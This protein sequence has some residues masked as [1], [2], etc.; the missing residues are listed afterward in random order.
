MTGDDAGQQAITYYE[1]HWDTGG[2]SWV[3]LV[4]QS[5]GS[6]TFSHTQSAG[7]TAGGA[8]QFKYRAANQHGVGEYSAVATI[9]ASA[10]PDQLASATTAN[11]GASVIVTWPLT[12]S[13]RGAT[14]TA[15]RVK[16][17]GTDGVYRE[18]AGCSPTDGGG[19]DDQAAFT[20]R[21]C[22]L[23]MTLFT[24]SPLSLAIDAPII[25]AVEAYNNKGHS[26]PSADDATGATAQT[27]P[28]EGPV[29]ARGGATTTTSLEV[30]WNEVTA[31][32]GNGGAAVTAYRVYWDQGLA[33]SSATP[34]LNNLGNW[35]LAATTDASVTRSVTTSSVTQGTT[36][37]FAVLAVN[38][39]GA[40]PVGATLSLLA[41]TAPDAP[42]GLTAG[43]ATATTVTF[44]WT[45][46]ANDGGSAVTDYKI[47]WNGSG[48]FY[49][50]LADTTSG[51]TTYTAAGLAASTSYGFQVSATNA[52]GSG[53]PSA[54]G[55]LMST[56][57]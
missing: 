52:V 47:Y 22:T 28:T 33:G 10:V 20:N 56:T 38:V 23:D 41:A 3:L 32:P 24:T 55:F 2:G 8:Y 54:V 4:L 21:Q 16:F 25:A 11:S 6:F 40:G 5:S 7:V 42:T 14:V 31:S 26:T 34:D 53:T 13:D 43:A 39:H 17:K 9:Y 57:A 19:T 44:T 30:T 15:Y 49:T 51:A 45:A 1:V 36:Y 48:A 29:A 50:I 37:Q 18:Q 27:E 35:Q 46:P 12:A